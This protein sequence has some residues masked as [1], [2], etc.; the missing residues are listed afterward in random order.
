MCSI[1]YIVIEERES[2]MS[3]KPFLDQLC[4]FIKFVL[5]EGYMCEK[6]FFEGKY[7]DRGK[8]KIRE[9]SLQ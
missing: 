7:S 9:R 2:M 1:L 8:L 3:E 4:I 6:S 5:I